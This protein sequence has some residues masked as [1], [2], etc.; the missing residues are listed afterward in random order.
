MVNVRKVSTLKVLCAGKISALMVQVSAEIVYVSAMDIAR[1]TCLCT[2]RCSMSSL[3][4]RHP[5][6]NLA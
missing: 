5:S 4:K 3:E 2:P 1:I 6:N